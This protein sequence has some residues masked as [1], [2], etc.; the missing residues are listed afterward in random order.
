MDDM[1]TMEQVRYRMEQSP[2]DFTW[3]AWTCPGC[4]NENVAIKRT[5]EV[6]CD[7]C[8]KQFKA[9]RSP[10]VATGVFRDTGGIK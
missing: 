5:Q 3:W 4:G 8:K 7:N 1:I 2:P 9:I 10:G 6:M